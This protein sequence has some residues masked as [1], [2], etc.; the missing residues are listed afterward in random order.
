MHSHDRNFVTIVDDEGFRMSTTEHRAV[1]A[2]A[3]CSVQTAVFY[4]RNVYHPLS[5]SAASV[6]ATLAG[7]RLRESKE[8]LR[9]ARGAIEGGK[10]GKS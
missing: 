4:P 9:T 6:T 1:S 7:Y 10:S 3:D 2:A 5:R 8:I